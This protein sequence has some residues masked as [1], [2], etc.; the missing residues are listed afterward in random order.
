VADLTPWVEAG[1]GHSHDTAERGGAQPTRVAQAH[2]RAGCAHGTTAYPSGRHIH[3]GAG[4]N[5]LA[6]GATVTDPVCGIQMDPTSAAHCH[7]G[8]VYF[9]SAGCAAA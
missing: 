4:S 2:D 3:D 7:T 8:T 9:C 6:G 1:S 5:G